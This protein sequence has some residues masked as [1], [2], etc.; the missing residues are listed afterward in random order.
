MHKVKLFFKN[1]FLTQKLYQ[2]LKSVKNNRKKMKRLKGP[3]QFMNR[4][5]DAET[6]CVILAGYKDFLWPKVFARIKTFLPENIDVCVASSGLYSDQLDKLCE[7]NGWSYLS[8]QRNCVT[9]V[10]N[11]AIHL[12]EHAKMIYKIDEDIFIT[13]HF[14][15]TLSKTYSDVS[16][17]GKYEVGFVAPLIPINGYGHVRI[18]EK[19]HLVDEYEKRFE[20]VKYASRSDRKIEKDPEAAKFFWGKDQMVGSIDEMD[21]EFYKAPYEYHACP[22]RFSIGAILFSRELWENMGM[23]I[24]DKGPCMGLDEEQIDSYCVMQSKS[25]II[26]EN[27]VVG[28]LSFGQQNKEIKNYFLQHSELF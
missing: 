12:H 1:F 14:F 10:Q 13:R 6:L 20:K 23:F 9:L 25:M 21:E 19:L 18:L 24:V 26:A 17:N 8:L 3:Y 22:I 27:T 2:F 16:A 4:K 11:I 7:E 28:H 5:T 15:E